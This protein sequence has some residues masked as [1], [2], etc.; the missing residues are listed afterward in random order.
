M[1]AGASFEEHSQTLV[2]LGFWP[3]ETCHVSFTTERRGFG[4]TASYRKLALGA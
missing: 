4:F 1:E 2:F 3:T